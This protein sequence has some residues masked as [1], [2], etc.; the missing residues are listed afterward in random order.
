PQ[1]GVGQQVE[2]GRRPQDPKAVDPG[3]DLELDQPGQGVLVERAVG[4]EGSG[5]RG[6][7]AVQSREVHRL[8]A[9]DRSEKISRENEYHAERPETQPG[10]PEH[11]WT[12]PASEGGSWNRV[13]VNSI[14]SQPVNSLGRAGFR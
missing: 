3:A 11:H 10:P 8:P 1:A 13:D 5:Q 7:D 12:I 2:P 4:F 6:D 9:L 14:W